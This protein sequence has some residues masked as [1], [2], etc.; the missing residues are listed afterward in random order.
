MTEKEIE[1]TKNQENILSAI[2]ENA[3]ITYTEI[4]KKIGL[5]KTATENNMK[6]LKE[7]NLIERLGEKTTGFWQINTRI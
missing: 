4:S 7:L 6:K 1:I 2:N 3:K 5:G